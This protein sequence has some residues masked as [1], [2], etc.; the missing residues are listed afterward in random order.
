MKVTPLLTRALLGVFAMFVVTA[1]GSA[2]LADRILRE[3]LTHEFESKGI[4]IAASIATASGVSLLQGNVG[5]IHELV[6]RCGDIQG[7]AY[8]LVRDRKNRVISHTFGAAPPPVVLTA[9]TRS[10]RPTIRSLS[11]GPSQPCIDVAYPIRQGADGYVHV[12]LDAAPVAASIRAATLE[13]LQLVAMITVAS[14]FL[15]ALLVNRISRPL[16][17]LSRYAA[18]LATAGWD[19]S[20][21]ESAGKELP[22]IVRRGDEVGQ[23]AQAFQH[24]LQELGARERGLRDAE[25]ALRQREHY[26][27]SLIEHASDVITIV[28]ADGTVRYES[29]AIQ[30]VLGYDPEEL[31]GTNAFSQVHPDDIGEVTAAFARSI[32]QGGVGRITEFRYRHKD[33]SWR[34]LEAVGRSLLGD[35]PSAGS[36][37]PRETLQS[38]AVPRSSARRRRPRR[39]RTTRRRHSWRT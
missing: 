1:C 4:A 39:P 33:G 21:T 30:H 14:L 13:Q 35:R 20:E 7:V 24:L 29:P 25:A 22:V 28:D 32:Q 16:R 17:W 10:N 27:R 18:T 6:D 26:F 34:V 23:F 15:T 36:S 5:S 2:Y 3:Q 8:V 19:A 12:G 38:D 9:N 31:V 11:L 37:S